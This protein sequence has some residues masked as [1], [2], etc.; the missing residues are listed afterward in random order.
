MIAVW[1]AS[2]GP[3]QPLN[4]MGVFGLHFA[5]IVD[6]LLG[7][8]HLFLFWFCAIKSNLPKIKLIIKFQ[9]YPSIIVNSR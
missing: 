2:L 8:C 1:L 6:V 5:C 4:C 7:F 9:K 3:R